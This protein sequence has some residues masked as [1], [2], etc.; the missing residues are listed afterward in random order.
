MTDQMTNDPCY[1]PLELFDNTDFECREPLEWILAGT[2][3]KICEIPCHVLNIR[4]DLGSWVPATVIGYDLASGFFYVKGPFEQPQQV[5]TIQLC[6]LHI[7]FDVCVFLFNGDCCLLSSQSPFFQLSH[8]TPAF[9]VLTFALGV[10]LLS[11]S[12]LLP[13]FFAFLFGSCRRSKIPFFS[14]VV[15]AGLMKSVEKLRRCCDMHCTLIA[16][17]LTRSDSWIM[18]KSIGFS[19]SA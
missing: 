7:L 13:F 18:S 17:P 1:L 19:P 6:R 2:R 9:P 3:G 15:S 8:I 10:Y 14:P 16:C 4:N 11:V 12:L 5:K